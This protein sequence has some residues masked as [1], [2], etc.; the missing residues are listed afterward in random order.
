MNIQEFYNMIGAD[1]REVEKRFGS[2][3]LI[4]RFV[5]KFGGDTTFDALK[6]AFAEG[7][8]EAAFR[9]AHTL[10][11]VSSN[12]GFDRLWKTSSE[13]TEYLRPGNATEG[14]KDLFA[15]VEQEYCAVL[16]AL[17]NLDI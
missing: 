6:T 3:R 10:K 17:K 16:A 5:S 2:E 12:L 13:L 15:A 9:A 1:Y 8:Q 4:V 11:G 14:A 7:N